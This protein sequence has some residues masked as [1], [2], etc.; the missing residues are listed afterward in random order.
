MVEE[1]RLACEETVPDSNFRNSK[2]L[3]PNKENS[4]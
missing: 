3:S 4:W 2:R 1:N